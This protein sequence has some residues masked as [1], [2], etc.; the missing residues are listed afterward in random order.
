MGFGEGLGEEIGREIQEAFFRAVLFLLGVAM[1]FMGTLLLALGSLEGGG[2]EGG[3]VI[4]GPFVFAYG[5]EVPSWLAAAL[6]AAT[7]AA[8]ALFLLA[9]RRVLGAGGEDH[10]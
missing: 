1:I 7:L 6:L 5:R 10:R 9:A 8:T 3:F 4:I 2:T